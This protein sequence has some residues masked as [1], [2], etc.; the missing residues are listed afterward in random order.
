MMKKSVMAVGV[1]ALLG[2][3]A[4]HAV[5]AFE[6]QATFSARTDKAGEMAYV[7]AN[8]MHYYTF[9]FTNLFYN[10]SFVSIKNI[11]SIKA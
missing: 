10:N 7:Q 5:V 4:A 1:A 3:S 8:G 9:F 11:R 6:D 2:M